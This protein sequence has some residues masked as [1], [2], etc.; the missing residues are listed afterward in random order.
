MAVPTPPT[1]DIEMDPDVAN[2]KGSK[3]AG[4][5]RRSDIVIL[6]SIWN[7]WSEPNDSR[8]FGSDVPNQVVRRDFCLVGRY[9]RN[10]AKRYEL[11]R[12]CTSPIS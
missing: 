12:R 2:R 8:R 5:L 10:P 7:D 1:Y 4:D 3:L 9:G 6:S 11:Y